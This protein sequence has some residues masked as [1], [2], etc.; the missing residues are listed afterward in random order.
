MGSRKD[1]DLIEQRKREIICKQLRKH[2]G[3]RVI[4][5]SNTIK[6]VEKLHHYLCKQGFDAEFYHG[7]CEGKSARLERF[8]ERTGENHGCARTPSVSVSTSPIFAL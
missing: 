2:K 4:I 8:T 1:A 3:E 6:R 5:Y 7:K